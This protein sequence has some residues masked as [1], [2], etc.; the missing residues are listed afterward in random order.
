MHDKTRKIVPLLLAGSILLLF[1]TGCTSTQVARGA[2][3]GAG[4]AAG[5][6]LGYAV[7]P[8]DPFR[9][10]E[11][12]AY[13]AGGA[14]LGAVLTHSMLPK[15]PDAIQ[16]GFD[17]GYQ[18]GVA[19]GARRTFHLIEQMHAAS[20]QGSGAMRYFTFPGPR[21]TEDGRILTDH[22]IQIPILVTP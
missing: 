19:H 11:T 4:S 22:E 1:A 14:I 10:G 16:R 20:D 3:V 15:D 7:S 13:T 2:T 6:A 8:K 5:A 17:D 12:A 9:P 18:H 21:I